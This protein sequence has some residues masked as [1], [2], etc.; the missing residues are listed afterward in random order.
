MSAED[1][2]SVNLPCPSCKQKGTLKLLDHRLFCDRSECNYAIQYT[3]PLC[4]TSLANL[5]FKRDDNGQFFTCESCEYDIH[6]KRIKHLLENYLIVDYAERCEFCNGPTVHRTSV[7]LGYRCFFFPRCSGQADLFNVSRES[8]VFLDFETTGL[9]AGKDHIIEIGALKID[10]EGFEHSY[11]TFVKPPIPNLPSKI[12]SITGITDEMLVDAPKLD[13]CIQD[14]IDFIGDA[15]LVAHNAKFDRA[16]IDKYIDVKTVWACSQKDIDWMERGFF[17][18]GLEMLCMWHGFY[19]GAHRAM[20]DV[21]ATINLIAH[22]SYNDNSPLIELISNSK[23]P[24][25]RIVNNFPYNKDHINLIKSRSKKY[26]YDPNSKSWIIDIN[27]P[28][29]AENE[30]VWLENNIYN[31]HFRGEIKKISIFDRY[32]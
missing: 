17:K 31:G 12:I 29:D 13:E 23:K 1:A 20:N 9:E 7:N 6:V 14:F 10:E 18:I 21:N 15:T 5:E 27:D 8:L 2:C 25:F 4:D 24:I 16:F 28:D 22:S 3:C 19:F 32:K 30:R 26:Y 11:S